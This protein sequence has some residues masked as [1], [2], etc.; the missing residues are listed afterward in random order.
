MVNVHYSPV[1][2][3]VF[4]VHK[5]EKWCCC[6]CHLGCDKPLCHCM[7]FCERFKHSKWFISEKKIENLWHNLSILLP[8]TVLEWTTRKNRSKLWS[9]RFQT[10]RAN[11]VD[12]QQT[13]RV[14]WVDT[15]RRW[16]SA[17]KRPR[18]CLQTEFTGNLALW[19]NAPSLVSQVESRSRLR[20]RFSNSICLCYVNVIY[21]LCIY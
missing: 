15:Y 11:E 13:G 8:W 6:D 12:Q 21:V 18:Q 16:Y 5:H 10:L 17:G 1:S 20:N 19:Q 4:L 7:R 9:G 14:W 3:G 2:I